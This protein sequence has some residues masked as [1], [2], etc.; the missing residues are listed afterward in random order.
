MS[1]GG[2]GLTG[3]GRRGAVLLTVLSS[4]ACHPSHPAASLLSHAACHCT[5]H[6]T[7]GRG[8][9]ATRYTGAGLMPVRAAF[10]DPAGKKGRPF[11]PDQRNMAPWVFTL[12][13]TF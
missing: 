11:T 2:G 1:G 4:K 7:T 8:Q 3:P 13:L 12:S 10:S 5:Q 9:R 6:L